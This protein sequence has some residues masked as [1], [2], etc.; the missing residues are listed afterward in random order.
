MKIIKFVFPL[1]IL[2]LIA[3]ILVTFGLPD[4]VPIHINLAGA[5]DGFASKWY[6]PIIGMIPIFI[7]IA[8]ILYSY[9]AN[10]IN[11]NKNVEDKIILVVAI[12]YTIVSWIPVFLALVLTNL[13]TPTSQSFLSVEMV[14][15]ISII[16]AIF[17]VFIGYY[18]EDIKP[19][20]YF[21][22]RTPWTLKNNVVWKKT[23]KLGSYTFMIAGFVLLVYAL[24][25]F[26]SGNFLY[27]IIG[28]I[29]AI[30]LAAAVP[31]IYS[32]YEY[33]KLN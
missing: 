32:Y 4:I 3:L 13:N 8:Y 29:I 16:L 20:R 27:A 9:T 30:F 6:I 15:S 1:A 33:K 25:T 5:V 10:E 14:A 7:A 21:G 28:W 19:N 26:I 11:L 2:N 24:A 18:V 17:F 31:I 23:H 12:F 22:I